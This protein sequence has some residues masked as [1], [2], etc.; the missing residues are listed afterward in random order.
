MLQGHATSGDSSG[1]TVANTFRST[2]SHVPAGQ[3]PFSETASDCDSSGRGSGVYKS[4]KEFYRAKNARKSRRCLFDGRSCMVS[5]SCASQA[6]LFV[7][8]DARIT[9]SFLP[10]K[11][12]DPKLYGDFDALG[13]VQAVYDTFVARVLYSWNFRP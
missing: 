13:C 8:H 6:K 2:G 7:I 10:H 3:V 12:L 9:T 11:T 5:T 1:T 4:S